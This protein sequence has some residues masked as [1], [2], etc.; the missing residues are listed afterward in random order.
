MKGSGHCKA[1]GL[2]WVRTRAGSLGTAGTHKCHHVLCVQG[3]CVHS[4]AAASAA[5]HTYPVHV[6]RRVWLRWIWPAG[7]LPPT[8][9]GVPNPGAVPGWMRGRL[10]REGWEM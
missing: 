9:T 3:L 10:S 8:W 6:A 5:K 7:G 1:P 4:R 2:V